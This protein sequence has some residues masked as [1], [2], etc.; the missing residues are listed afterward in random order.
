M[1]VRKI[2]EAYCNK[3]NYHDISVTTLHKFMKKRMNLRFKKLN[4]TSI[5]RKQNRFVVINHLF[6]KKFIQHIT[7]SKN[8]I[9]IDETCFFGFNPKLKSWHAKNNDE[10]IYHHGR[11][12]IF[13][14]LEPW[15]SKT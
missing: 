15:M 6:C 8:I 7:N 14:F 12:K 1:S 9:F 13:V 4:L 10:P 2:K 11:F 3:V 5:K